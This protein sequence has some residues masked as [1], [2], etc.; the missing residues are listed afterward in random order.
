MGRHF[1]TG[2]LMP[3][4]DTLLWFQRDLQLEQQWLLD[5]SH[6]QRTA[7]AWLANHDTH[8]D[9]VMQLSGN[10]RR[11]G[12]AP[13]VPALADLLDGVRGTLRAA[14]RARVDGRALP[15]PAR[16]TAALRLRRAGGERVTRSSATT[17]PKALAD[18]PVSLYSRAFRAAQG[19]PHAAYRRQALAGKDRAAGRRSSP[20]SCRKPSCAYCTPLKSPCPWRSR[21]S[22]HEIGQTRS[23]SRTSRLAGTA[24]TRSPDTGSTIP[25]L[26]G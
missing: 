26:T 11:R 3:A 25:G 1:F 4:A 19:S 9:Q 23:T 24:S 14:G 21:K 12:G 15:L 22:T 16:G 8:H 2:G 17:L 6:Y 18:P 7:E 20:R 10:L 13:V 5:G